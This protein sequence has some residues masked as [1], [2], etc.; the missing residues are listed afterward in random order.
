MSIFETYSIPNQCLDEVFSGERN[1]VKEPYHKIISVFNSLSSEQFERLNDLIKISFFNQG[2]TY[3]VYSEKEKKEHIFPFDPFPRLI[4]KKEWDQIEKGTIQ[5]SL[6]LNLFIKD[7]YNDQKVLKDKIVP[8]EMILSSK[9]FRK[10]MVGFKP[11][12]GIYCHINGTDLIKNSDGNN[13][14]LEDNLRSP[15]GVSYVLSNREALK[16]TMSDIFQSY[17]ILP[18]WDYPMSLLA[19][20]QSVKPKTSD[21]PV[22]VVLTPGMYNSAYYEHMFLAK[23]M[24]IEL[25]EGHDLV[26]EDDYVYMKTTDGLIKV[27]VIYRRIDDDFLDSEVFN[28]ESVLGVKGLMRSYNRGNVTVVNAP[29]TGVAD[30]KAVYSYVPKIIKYYLN[31]DPILNN[32]H[33]YICENPS[34]LDYVINN[35]ENLVVK[36]VDQSGGY[37]ISIGNKLSQQELDECKRKIKD[38]PRQ[39]IAQPIMALTTHATYID[40]EGQ[41]SPR[42]VDLRTYTLIGNDYQYVLKGG[43]SRVALKKGSLIVN[44]SQ[45]GGSK[46]T[47]VLS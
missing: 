16:R 18:V 25:V 32:V 41:F 37:G 47:W 9:N 5:R 12:G 40:K 6:A 13:Y 1:E 28:K 33:T 34:D 36:P 4:Q 43:L 17:A 30:D 42:H 8:A 20:M 22:C 26:M 15:S 21:Q 44:S 29:G 35:L 31:E 11:P 7:L 19:M 45:G 3:Q 24:G 38:S 14:V 39:F 46:D 23:Q 2:I 10:E 27:D